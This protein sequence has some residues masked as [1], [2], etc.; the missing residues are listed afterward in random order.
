LNE[1]QSNSKYG[2]NEESWWISFVLAAYALTAMHKPL[3]IAA[4]VT[5]H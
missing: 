2:R 5:P 1:I 3:C 4:P